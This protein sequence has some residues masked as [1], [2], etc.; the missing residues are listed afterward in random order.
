MRTYSEY[1]CEACSFQTNSPGNAMAHYRQTKY[2]SLK[3]GMNKE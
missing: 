2:S 3:G 1:H